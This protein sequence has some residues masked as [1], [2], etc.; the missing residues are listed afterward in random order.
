MKTIRSNHLALMVAAITAL[1]PFGIDAYLPAIPALASHL[2]ASIHL[3]STSISIFLVG[4]AFGQLV[5]GPLSDR[6]GRR[7]VLIFGTLVFMAACIGLVFVS[8]L[9]MLW[10]LRF[11]QAIGGGAC[12][13]NSS[14]IVRDR[15]SGQDAARVFS[16]M[17]MILMLA[18]LVAPTLGSVLLY[19]QGWQLVFGFLFLYALLV[20]LIVVFFLPETRQR[21]QHPPSALMVIKHYGEVLTHRAAVGYMLAVAMSFAGMFAFITSSPYVYMGYYH[22]SPALYP[23]LF[24]ANIVVMAGSNQLNIRLLK[25]VA[26]RKIMKVGLAIQ[27]VTAALL[28]LCIVLGIDRLWMVVIL[29]MLFVGTLG[30]V[31]ANA[32]SN[33]LDFFPHMSATANAVQGSIQFTA[34]ALSG[35][36]LGAL[37][38][39]GVLPM[40]FMMMITALLANV[41]V[42]WLSE[43]RMKNRQ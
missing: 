37:G 39:K 6:I 21:P 28:V 17:V 14:A 8:S 10:V 27:L 31:S 18:P 33:M 11:V 3:T 38:Q 32:T 22:V 2:G 29:V 13:V 5:F 15:F 40:A 4:F 16:T 24:G 9:E 30:L 23:V 20:L 1:A 43:R 34:G 42:R 26:A 12:V 25:H 35:G 41:L 36:L 19:M 7:P